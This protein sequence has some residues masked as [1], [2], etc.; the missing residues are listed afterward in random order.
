MQ[1][2][3]FNGQ[4]TSLKFGDCLHVQIRESEKS[5]VVSV[6]RNGGTLLNRDGEIA[7]ESHR[8]AP[9]VGA[10][11]SL[12]LRLYAPSGVARLEEVSSSDRLIVFKIV[13][14]VHP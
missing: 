13:E 8:Y 10:V 4:A 11:K 6:C 9:S 7:Y 14:L 1:L 12:I 5:V 3:D 2:F